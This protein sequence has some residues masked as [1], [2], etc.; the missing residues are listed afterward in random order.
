MVHGI[1]ASTRCLDVWFMCGCAVNMCVQCV[2]FQGLHDLGL[3][4]TLKK[5][6]VG[7]WPMSPL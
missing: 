3:W 1:C 2:T 7:V 6:L 4:G 5:V